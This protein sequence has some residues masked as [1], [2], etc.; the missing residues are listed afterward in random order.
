M[1]IVVLGGAGM[2]GCIAVKDLAQSEDV[3]EVVIADLSLERTAELQEAIASPKV[4]V[5]QVDV[6]DDKG[7]IA[8]LRGADCVLNATVYYFNLEVMKACLEAKVDY[9]DLGGLFHLTRKQLELHEAFE[10]AG[11]TAVLGMGSAPGIPNIQSR[12][13]A[14]RLETVEYVHIYDGI[15]PSEGDE[16]RF[17]YAVATIIDEATMEPMVYRDGEFMAC[18]PFSEMEEYWFTPPIGLLR[19]HLSLHS[20]VATIPLTFKEKGVRE[21]FFKINSWGLPQPTIEKVKALVELGFASREPVEVKGMKVEPRDV[22]LTLLTSHVPP[23][24]TFLDWPPFEL[25]EWR[26]EIVTEVKGTRGGKEVIYCLRTLTN[27]G[28]LPTGVAPSIVAQWLGQGWLDRP[29]AFPPEVAIAPGP[30]FKDLEKRGIKTQVTVT[31][32]I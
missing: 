21:C 2:M 28:S 16:V 9:T 31:E 26:K 20:E 6:T 5:V 25:E 29:G 7:L 19:T 13:A 1:K 32:L 4:S 18:Q 24:R 8:V 12:Y 23:I 22:L 15:L 17:G 11:I 14:E 30:F 27:F 3:D 10:E